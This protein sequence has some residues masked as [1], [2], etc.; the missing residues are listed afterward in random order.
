M[1]EKG[2][3]IKKYRTAFFLSY[4]AVFVT[5]RDIF[6]KFLSR[7][8]FPSTLSGFE[9]LTGSRENCHE[10][11]LNANINTIIKMSLEYDDSKQYK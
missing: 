1:K 3:P 8:I 11:I 9:T 2:C 5:L 7:A 6:C 10:P 4:F